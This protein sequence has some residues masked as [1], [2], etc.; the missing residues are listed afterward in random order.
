MVHTWHRS[1][2]REKAFL[3]KTPVRAPVAEEDSDELAQSHA[4]NE[5]ATQSS[6]GDR[7]IVELAALGGV[8]RRRRR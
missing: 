1:E 7:F 4:H 6:S 2:L 3:K 5:H 8:R